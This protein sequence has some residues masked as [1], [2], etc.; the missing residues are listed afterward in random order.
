MVMAKIQGSILKCPCMMLIDT[1]SKLNIMMSDH[2]SVMELPVD[3]AGAA[4]TLQGVSSHQI[5]LE[6][7]CR[8]VLIMIGGV[9]VAHN[10]FIMKDKLNGK[11]IILG[12][13]WLFGHSTWIDCIHDMGM[14]IQVWNEGDQENGTSVKIKL[15]ILTALLRPC[16]WKL[17]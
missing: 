1:G 9:E 16:Q 7:L 4:W 15:P 5:A 11:D 14:V 2:A 8:D 3:P 6:G 12:Q 17:N 10:F 13:P